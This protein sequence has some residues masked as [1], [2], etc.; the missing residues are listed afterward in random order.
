MRGGS[1]LSALAHGGGRVDALRPQF[2]PATRCRV[3]RDIKVPARK[4]IQ[5]MF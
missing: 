1:P 4:G 2:R 5:D 3:S